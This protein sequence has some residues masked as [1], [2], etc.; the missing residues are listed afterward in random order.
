MQLN[1]M[2]M[3][4]EGGLISYDWEAAVVVVGI[5]VAEL[6]GCVEDAEFPGLISNMG[7]NLVEPATFE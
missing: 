6:E 3:A 2:G 5:I 7:A 1:L 4:S